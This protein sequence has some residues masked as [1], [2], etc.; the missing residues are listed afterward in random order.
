L[1]AVICVYLLAAVTGALRDDLT[2]REV[3]VSNTAY[4]RMLTAIKD[5]FRFNATG[6]PIA[7]PVRGLGATDRFFEARGR[8]NA[9]FTCNTWI[10]SILRAAGQDF[11]VWTPTPYAVT[12]SQKR[13]HTP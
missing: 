5:S 13:F 10:S 9:V 11:G 7:V 8:F 2:I 6:Q 3:K 4:T 12:L 1:I